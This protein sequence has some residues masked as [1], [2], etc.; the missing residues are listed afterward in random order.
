ML[1]LKVSRTV[2]D[3]PNHSIFSGAEG[4]GAKLLIDQSKA[5]F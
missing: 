4:M 5:F 3:P 1:K 2:D